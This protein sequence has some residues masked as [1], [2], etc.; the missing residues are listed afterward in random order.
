MTATEFARKYG[1]DQTTAYTASF[2]TPTRK[3]EHTTEFP[4]EELKQAVINELNHRIEYYQSKVDLNKKRLNK[5][6]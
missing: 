1:I 5:L 3:R 4:E 6:V 2:Q